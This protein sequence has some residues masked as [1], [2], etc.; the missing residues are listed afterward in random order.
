MSTST[1]A[2]AATIS[3]AERIKRETAP[4]W[5]PS[6][7]DILIGQFVGVRKAGKSKEMGGYG[8]YYAILLQDV[9]GDY[10]AVHAFHTVLQNKLIKELRPHIGDWLTLSYI[11]SVI[12]TADDVKADPTLKV[13]D[14]RYHNYY[15]EAGQGGDAKVT[16]EE[17][18]W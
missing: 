10:W 15:L 12:V 4:A 14:T 16:E 13:G 7:G 8:E 1:K 3:L 17:I 11:G 6:P 2:T 5:K 9:N 18:P